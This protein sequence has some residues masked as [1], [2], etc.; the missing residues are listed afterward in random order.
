MMFCGTKIQI[1]SFLR[2][3]ALESA[4][5]DVE[6]MG[7]VSGRERAVLCFVELIISRRPFH[8]NCDNVL[9]KVPFSFGNAHM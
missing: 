8:V 2:F 6:C 1:F 9:I 7:A 3:F 5:H 4:L